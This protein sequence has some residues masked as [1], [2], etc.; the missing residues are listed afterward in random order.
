MTKDEFIKTWMK[1]RDMKEYD[2]DQVKQYYGERLTK[3]M[4]KQRNKK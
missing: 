1:E 4:R 3:N 2:T